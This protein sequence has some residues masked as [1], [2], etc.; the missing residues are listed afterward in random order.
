[1]VRR[2]RRDVWLCGFCALCLLCVSACGGTATLFRQYEYEEEVYLS[3]DGS[4]TVYVNSSLPALN[5]LRGTSFDAGPAARVDTTAIR[6][7]FT[8]PATRV[9]RVSQSRRNNRRFVHVRLDVAD[10]TQLGSATPFAWS[11]YAFTRDGDQY[12]YLQTV[13]APAGKPAG[14]AGWNGS[15]LVAFRLHL[16]SK[17]RYHN[18]GRPVGRG[19]ILVW[20]QLL[21]DRLKNVPVVY[22]EKGDGVLDARMD[23]QSILYT[24]LWLFATTFLV[25]AVVFGIVIWWV[26]RRGSRE[27]NGFALLAI[28]ALSIATAATRAAQPTPV[29]VELFTSEGCADCPPADA[30]LDTLIATQPVA[31]ARIIGLGQHVDYWDRLGWKDR[32]SS[33]AVT[34]RQQQYQTRFNTE[35]IYTPQMVVDGRA[36]FVGS[37]A[38]AARKAIAKTLTA[39]HGVVTLAADGVHVDVRVTDLPRVPRGDR[40]DIIV[41]VTE[42][43]LTTDVKRGENHGKVLTHAPVVRYLAAIGQI[44]AESTSGAARGDVA[45]DA[46]WRRDRLTLIAFVQENRGRNILASASAPFK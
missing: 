22:A 43:G 46:G 17:I 37:D 40:A 2:S 7:W 3:L 6:A 42:S 45:L 4:A 44:A 26:V 31:G 28:A 41:M 27:K 15:E 34:A 18:T 10:I 23:H 16:P 5:A 24:T 36:E 9:I 39:P 20:E 29:I 35:S 32:F 1:M 12:K 21:T 33:A 13:G 14:D 19:N 38:G 25:V 11:K 8:S 30:L